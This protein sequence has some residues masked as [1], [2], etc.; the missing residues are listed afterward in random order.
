MSSNIPD[1]KPEL[2]LDSLFTKFDH[3][4]SIALQHR[5]KYLAAL[6]EMKKVK[7][8]IDVALGRIQSQK[9]EQE[10]LHQRKDASNDTI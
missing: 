6:E 1:P 10:S 2:S 7:Q 8:E 3:F 5:D 4:N 9:I